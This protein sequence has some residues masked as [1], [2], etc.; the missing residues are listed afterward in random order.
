[1]KI[2]IYILLFVVLIFFIFLILTSKTGILGI[3]N[4][5][6]LSGSME[7]EIKTGSLVFVS[8]Q[9]TYNEGDIITFYQN[10]QIIVTHRIISIA[11]QGAENQYI[12]KGDANNINDKTLVPNSGVIGKEIFS[13]PYVGSFSLFLKTLPGLIIFIIFPALI[14]ITSEVIVVI[15]E[16][17][18]AKDNIEI[19]YKV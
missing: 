3:K 6:V 8:P 10:G 9:Q 16:I 18:E 19:F 2:I 11:P 13:I 15:K 12:T 14:F 4:F 7:P 5:A 17:S 1:M